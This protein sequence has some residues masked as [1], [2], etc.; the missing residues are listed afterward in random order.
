[1]MI[2]KDAIFLL[3]LFSFLMNGLRYDFNET[4]APIV[5]RQKAQVFA[6]ADGCVASLGT[7]LGEDFLT[8]VLE[9]L[10]A[11]EEKYKQ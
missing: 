5:E 8:C 2:P 11:A 3:L 1:M 9:D 7:S 10:R 4:I 6:A